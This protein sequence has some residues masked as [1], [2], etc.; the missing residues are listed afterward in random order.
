MDFEAAQAYLL[1]T[2]NE[3]VS[4][5]L[6]YRLER[7]RAFLH[8][9]GDPQSRYPTVHIGGTSGKGSTSTMI[10]AAFARAGKRVG[11]HTKPHL[12]SM[13]ERARI[14]GIA[15]SEER[16]AV[17][18]DEMMPAIE[19]TTQSHGRPTYYETLLGLTLLY[20]AQERVDV[21][22]VEVGLGGRLDGTNVIVPVVAAITSVGLDHTD[23]LGESLEEIAF[24]KA[25]IAKPGVPLVVA[26]EN[27]AAYAVIAERTREVGAPLIDAREAAVPVEHVRVGRED[28]SFEVC[29][30]QATYTIE[31][32]MLGV[33]QRRNAATAIVTMEAL[34]DALRPSPAQIESA[35]A[36]VVIPGRM[37]VYPGHP[38]LVFDI[39]HNGEKA[40][41]LVRSLRERYSGRHFTFVVAIGASKD[42]A[43]ILRTLASLPANFVFTSFET[44]G[45][46]ATNPM[47]LLRIAEAI[48][49]WGRC[50]GDP[51]EAL[52]VARRSAAA[53]DVIV[54][55]GS[56]FLVAALREWWLVAA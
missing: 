51:V 45:R 52:S 44:A 21:A 35:F 46:Q 15:V 23:V 16:F 49:S 7:M 12:R 3:T 9:L 17:L 32:R 10:A 48:G 36:D 20:F 18:L 2:I 5:R 19:R 40:E 33:F 43:E 37:E 39:A 8:E 55:T 42:A 47:R 13:T 50:V 31:T 53:N 30:T 11:L 24:E 38:T 34:P 29:T 41:Q 14:D 6:P 27:E 56:T 54:V 4:R 1:A 26:V 25:G 28:Q 22:V